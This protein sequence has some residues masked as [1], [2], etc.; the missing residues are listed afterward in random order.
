MSNSILD[1]FFE[2]TEEL[3]EALAEGL[4]AMQGGDQ[5]AET[6]NSVFRAVHSIKG[7]AGA[8]KLTELVGFAHHFETVLDAV[9]SGTLDLTPAIMHTLTRSADF[10]VNLVEAARNGA[11]I[12]EDVTAGFLA[13]LQVCFG[14]EAI[15]AV[16]AWD[17]FEF[18]ALPL[19]FGAPAEEVTERDQTRIGFQI[20]FRPHAALYANGHEPALLFAALAELGPLTTRLNLDLLPDW[21]AFDPTVPCLAWELDLRSE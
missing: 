6:V 15:E 19:D 21:D 17:N 4:A 20:A 7:G 2:E 1:T 11:T 8:F 12:D 14:D 10:L 18:A 9:R 3:L 5:E 13:A 16:D